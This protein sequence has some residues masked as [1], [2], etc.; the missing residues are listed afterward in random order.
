M[1]KYPPST[2]LASFG[3]SRQRSDGGTNRSSASLYS[4]TSGNGSCS[5]VAF[6]LLCAASNV[7]PTLPPAGQMERKRLS[8]DNSQYSKRA[9][10]QSSREL[11]ETYN[12][13]DS[14]PSRSRRKLPISGETLTVNKGDGA[15]MLPKLSTSSEFDLS[16]A[17]S[18]STPLSTS[19][20]S[21][22]VSS[23]NTSFS[24]D[25]ATSS[26]ESSPEY[27]SCPEKLIDSDKESETG[28]HFSP[29]PLEN[30]FHGVFRKGLSTSAV[31]SETN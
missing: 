25:N 7:L 9:R 6:F 5:I 16:F 13:I 4:T 14:V 30:L 17:S 8:A 21:S 29:N 20:N 15:S 26:E 31:S 11:S 10:C 28:V 19:H 12:N 18:T 1:P 24:T 3:L 23:K 22:F 2:S 27:F